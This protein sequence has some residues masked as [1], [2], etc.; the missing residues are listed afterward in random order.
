MFKAFC[1]ISGRRLLLLFLCLILLSSC[2]SN[3]ECIPAD[4]FGSYVYSQKQIIPAF[5]PSYLV[6][7]D[8]LVA[9]GMQAANNPTGAANNS[10]GSTSYSDLSIPSVIAGTTEN[11]AYLGA[12]TEVKPKS[13]DKDENAVDFVIPSGTSISAKVD[14]FVE[15]A[16]KYESMVSRVTPEVIRS[17]V[18]TIKSTKT[19]FEPG[20]MVSIFLSGDI[21][22]ND[23]YKIDPK[24]MTVFHIEQKSTDASALAY[25]DPGNWVCNVGSTS[26]YSSNIQNGDSPVCDFVS[27]EGCDPIY[28]SDRIKD[29]NYMIFGSGY[30]EYKDASGNLVRGERQ[31]GK[32][33]NYEMYDTNS[34]FAICTS[35]KNSKIPQTRANGME[36]IG[37]SDADYPD[38]N[39]N[40]FS[41]T[42]FNT[43]CESAASTYQMADKG[44]KYGGLLKYSVV[45]NFQRSDWNGRNFVVDNVDRDTKSY[46]VYTYD[47]YD[48]KGAKKS[49]PDG[50]LEICNHPPIKTQYPKQI[51]LFKS[52]SN[53]PLAHHG[54]NVRR[55]GIEQNLRKGIWKTYLSNCGETPYHLSEGTALNAA[56]AF[57]S[58]PYQAY[59]LMLKGDNDTLQ[60]QN[61]PKIQDLDGWKE[62]DPIKYQP[63]STANGTPDGVG[64]VTTGCSTGAYKSSCSGSVQTYMAEF[65]GDACWG[66]WVLGVKNYSIW[67]FKPNDLELMDVNKMRDGEYV[68]SDFIDGDYEL[69]YRYG[70]NLESKSY[71]KDT[72]LTGD[73]SPS[74]KVYAG[75][76]VN[77]YALVYMD[78]GSG[79]SVLPVSFGKDESVS[80]G[81]TRGDTPKDEFMYDHE[82]Q[83]RTDS[84]QTKK[85]FSV[86]DNRLYQ[87][88]WD[89]YGLI[90]SKQ[91][92]TG[93]SA[94][95]TKY[96][97]VVKNKISQYGW[98]F[99]RAPCIAPSNRC[100]AYAAKWDG[101]WY[102][103]DGNDPSA[104][105]SANYILNRTND[106][107]YYGED[108]V[109]CV[110]KSGKNPFSEFTPNIYKAITAPKPRNKEGTSYD[111]TFVR[112]EFLIKDYIN[113]SCGFSPSP[114]SS[115]R[116]AIYCNARAK[117][118][119]Y[120]KRNLSYQGEAFCGVGG[121]G[122]ST[123]YNV[124]QG[125]FNG[126]GDDNPSVSSHNLYCHPDKTRQCGIAMGFR[127]FQ[128]EIHRCLNNG[129]GYTTKCN[130]SRYS[131]VNDCQVS[132]DISLG[133]CTRKVSVSTKSGTIA[134]SYMMSYSSDD[135]AA[136]NG[137]KVG[138][139]SYKN[140]MQK[141]VY[142]IYNTSSD[143]YN[144]GGSTVNRELVDF[145]NCGLCLIDKNAIAN[146]LVQAANID[147]KNSNRQ[148]CQDNFITSYTTNDRSVIYS[149][150]QNA[151]LAKTQ[152]DSY[153]PDPSNV[154]SKT[155]PING[156]TYLVSYSFQPIS[157]IAV[158]E[159]SLS[160]IDNY[161][162]DDGVTKETE[163]T[164]VVRSMNSFSAA[165]SSTA[166]GVA[167]KK[168]YSGRL[169]QMDTSITIPS[170]FGKSRISMY[171][172]GAKGLSSTDATSGFNNIRPNSYV[173]AIL[174]SSTPAKFG[175]F[176]YFYIQP[177]GSDGK[178]DPNYHPKVVFPTKQSFEDAILKKD[179]R[180]ISFYENSDMSGNASFM[181]KYPGKVWAII[182]DRPKDSS[183]VKTDHDGSYINFDVPES[184]SPMSSSYEK[185]AV[186]ADGSNVRSNNSGSYQVL[187]KVPTGGS[188][189]SLLGTLIGF[190][191]SVQEGILDMI[192]NQFI[193]KPKPG[194]E[195]CK[196]YVD[197]TTV[198][199]STKQAKAKVAVTNIDSGATGAS[200]ICSGS[201]NYS[202][203]FKTEPSAS[204]SGGG[205][206][207]AVAPS[208]QAFTSYSG[209]ACV[210]KNTITL[211]ANA[212]CAPLMTAASPIVYSYGNEDDP[213]PQKQGVFSGMKLEEKLAFHRSTILTYCG[214]D[215][216]KEVDEKAKSSTSSY[217]EY[218][219]AS[220]ACYKTPSVKINDGEMFFGK[221]P[222]DNMIVGG[223]AVQYFYKNIPN[224]PTLVL[225]NVSIIPSS[226]FSNTTCFDFGLANYERQMDG[227]DR[228][229]DADCRNGYSPAKTAECAVVPGWGYYYKKL[230]N[231]IQPALSI[232]TYTLKDDD[233]RLI[234]LSSIGL[235]DYNN[236]GPNCA[237]KMQ[238][239]KSLWTSPRE[240][241]KWLN[242]V[243]AAY[244]FNNDE[245][246]YGPANGQQDYSDCIEEIVYPDNW[247]S[248]W[249]ESIP[250]TVSVEGFVDKIKIQNNGKF[251]QKTILE[252]VPCNGW[253]CRDQI[254]MS[255]NQYG[256][257]VSSSENTEYFAIKG[258]MPMKNRDIF[259]RHCE[260][261]CS[262]FF[263]QKASR[264][265]LVAFQ[266][267][268]DEFSYLMK[269]K[270]SIPIKST[271]DIMFDVYR[272]REATNFS[273]CAMTTDEFKMYTMQ[274]V[275]PYN[276][277]KKPDQ[278]TM[279]LGACFMDPYAVNYDDY[280]SKTLI[281][282]DDNSSSDKISINYTL[283]YVLDTS[284]DPNATC[285]D[286]FNLGNA[287]ISTIEMP[288]GAP[289]YD[290]PLPQRYG[291]C[292]VGAT[293]G[294]KTCNIYGVVGGL[295]DA[296]ALKNCAM[297]P[298]TNTACWKKIAYPDGVFR[299]VDNL[300]ASTNNGDFIKGLTM[301]DAGTW[302]V[303]YSAVD[304]SIPIPKKLYVCNRDP[305]KNLWG[306][307]DC[308][309]FTMKD[310]IPDHKKIKSCLLKKDFTDDSCWMRGKL[311]NL[312]S[313]DDKRVKD[314]LTSMLPL[315]EKS[316]GATSN[317]G[318]V[319][320]QNIDC[321]VK[322]FANSTADSK[323]ILVDL[324]LSCPIVDADKAAL[325]KDGK[326]AEVKTYYMYYA[327]L[328]TYTVTAQE[329]SVSGN[330]FEKSVLKYDNDALKYWTTVPDEFSDS[331]MGINP[332]WCENGLC[333]GIDKTGYIQAV[334]DR[335]FKKTEVQQNIDQ[336]INS[337]SGGGAS[338]ISVN[339]TKN[340]M[341]KKYGNCG[342]ATA[343]M[344]Q[345]T[346]FSIN[347]SAAINFQSQLKCVYL[348]LGSTV[349]QDNQTF[350]CWVADKNYDGTN[351]T[352]YVFAPM[353]N[354]ED[355]SN[356]AFLYAPAPAKEIKNCVQN[357][358]DGSVICTMVDR[359]FNYDA[360][361]TAV[362][363]K[364][365]KV[366]QIKIPGEYSYLAIQGEVKNSAVTR[367][368]YSDVT[369]CQS[370]KSDINQ[371]DCQTIRSNNYAYLCTIGQYSVP[372]TADEY[373]AK[374][375]SHYVC[376]VTVPCEVGQY[377]GGESKH[378]SVSK[379]TVSAVTPIAAA[380]TSNNVAYLPKKTVCSQPERDY[381]TGMIYRVFNSITHS[382]AYQAAYYMA[383]MLFV[384]FVAM[385]V[386]TG[387]IEVNWKVFSEQT[388]K[389]AYVFSVTS[390]GG[391]NLVQYILAKFVDFITS[392]MMSLVAIG[393]N[394]GNEDSLYPILAM[395]N[396]I[397]EIFSN[398]VFWFKVLAIFPTP[399]FPTGFFIGIPVMIGLVKVF[400]ILLK[401]VIHY[402]SSVITFALYVAITPLVM[403][404]RLFDKTKK[405]HDSWLKNVI[406]GPFDML[407]ALVGVSIVCMVMHYILLFFIGQTV[408]WKLFGID[409]GA[410]V[411]SITGLDITLFIPLFGFWAIESANKYA[412]L[413]MSMHQGDVSLSDMMNSSG[414][415]NFGMPTIITAFII[416]AFVA[417]CEKI[418]DILNDFAGAMGGADTKDMFKSI[419]EK[420]DVPNVNPVQVMETSIDKA[421]D[422]LTAKTQQ[423]RGTSEAEAKEA[424]EKYKN[425]DNYKRKAENVEAKEREKES[426]NA[427]QNTSKALEE[428]RKQLG[429]NAT[430]EAIN[431]RANDINA[432]RA[433]NNMKNSLAD[434]LSAREMEKAGMNAPR[435]KD[436]QK[437]ALNT[438][439]GGLANAL[440]GGDENTRWGRFRNRL[441]KAIGTDKH[442]HLNKMRNFIRNSSVDNM[443]NVTDEQLN[444]L[445]IDE[446]KR[447][448]AREFLRKTADSVGNAGNEARRQFNN[449]NNN[450][451]NNR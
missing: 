351:S 400:L 48:L 93:F 66:D 431:N 398:S 239:R 427:V 59:Y 356:G 166:T 157:K 109:K 142:N 423:W 327:Y 375:V 69:N 240:I 421:G 125:Y 332:L 201:T 167:S 268:D 190:G 403:P 57:Y 107:L 90:D 44:A 97:N 315:F 200:E 5:P 243:N 336:Q 139:A 275:M 75:N 305:S 152:F 346:V 445:G 168:H 46:S 28:T 365:E 370:V 206:S 163:D 175:K 252:D 388:F 224:D 228:C 102:N 169:G 291:D 382:A 381:T 38:A 337:A 146:G 111:D 120:Q 212:P 283:S 435:D 436:E 56:S 35:D 189:A 25:S 23:G 333:N 389:I 341:P 338:S 129:K 450:N 390:P 177:I 420:L 294:K 98:C 65:S 83:L 443:R 18:D 270:K 92:P 405:Y 186:S 444:S 4:D 151:D 221:I 136:A 250:T 354:N 100:E 397:L 385:N 187:L 174:N 263:N 194:T 96:D 306:E 422:A 223:N 319:Y 11:M 383:L 196:T 73:I 236:F 414:G 344:K 124:A 13:S 433:Q 33:V 326:F 350:Q 438:L 314:G 280:A 85:Y 248:T 81:T 133:V 105:E 325:Q 72:I 412:S 402:I 15:L 119:P 198:G 372:A 290:W 176:L 79:W 322:W 434:A 384:V 426:Q 262:Y 16:S 234:W 116:K 61:E 215:K 219:T 17:G 329:L 60:C 285:K 22:T 317:T 232:G 419:T 199:F 442:N 173:V 320:D 387:K 410:I 406:R 149:Q 7:S 335:L 361:T 43:T 373:S 144:A 260:K 272:S 188:K 209:R 408:C 122:T 216:L 91:N 334:Q 103:L 379:L 138:Q 55:F 449:I 130:V 95:K 374:K 217:V 369:N 292:V 302:P 68:F 54:F 242:R 273:E 183:G 211:P 121:D 297:Q 324:G 249:D 286:I 247:V 178:V 377:V 404:F 165:I 99:E 446:S 164:G 19:L 158:C 214:A 281:N 80:F 154:N 265:N 2:G 207:G 6:T 231:G 258:S 448:K 254:D 162:N 181:S 304:W 101:Q 87:R 255:P 282:L 253:L 3:D 53:D 230:D 308:E 141:Q 309:S 288:N 225:S 310:L 67:G 424:M 8:S 393:F 89:F 226:K 34:G 407:F 321:F 279:S 360:N 106:K 417:F 31:A 58:D 222:A 104:F 150:D 140:L 307:I 413:L 137:K 415:G 364:E 261:K 235:C 77:K 429:P 14:G 62:G 197:L 440:N 257:G 311:I 342:A 392:G 430:R 42:Y 84:Y 352:K 218:K 376:D 246:G 64:G 153:N 118:R 160:N 298:I 293:S 184:I 156:D 353:Y 12:W 159:D 432:N 45:Q 276:L 127:V 191:S 296:A 301:M 259:I 358:S 269:S 401:G 349:S 20:S 362:T 49:M 386:M 347:G 271:T 416:F 132:R 135:V 318:G 339:V 289:A 391:W 40:A 41:G 203:S 425:S 343:N 205:S 180:I 378:A 76:N 437:G 237:Y 345:C 192:F 123:T 328:D 428:A 264:P 208:L 82:I 148:S 115:T 312:K 24:E 21:K 113:N 363:I 295:K 266:F 367:L 32:N 50:Y 9:Q 277:S 171:M 394:L 451:N 245:S 229:L 29:E 155:T 399:P 210:V 313:L 179:G 71:N 244:I 409:V 366:N 185:M 303:S 78:N 1:N 256:V 331:R 117:W 63:C 195:K 316:F 396:N 182:F 88:N 447:A 299:T 74:C 274:D 70:N 114:V 128:G 161:Y 170:D 126:P 220:N 30:V 395:M 204:A 359:T 357:G 37:W 143:I 439:R 241:S 39:I 47:R 355:Y 213:D 287:T 94:E 86:S 418:L 51:F 145:D 251:L 330:S 112:P 27:G 131:N 278:T 10:A 227:N 284:K 411:K 108:D 52:L 368:E 371:S 441:S 172:A 323:Y 348:P 36:Y 134:A 147:K 26:S 300:D 380:D 233:R 267:N 193:G 110:S 340:N 238:S 202:M